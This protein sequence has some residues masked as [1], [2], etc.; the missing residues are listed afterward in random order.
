VRRP[1]QIAQTH[2]AWLLPLRK[3]VEKWIVGIP[4][5]KMSEE[6]ESLEIA[7]MVG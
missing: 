5:D 6:V 4:L 2:T 1:E 3:A 7:L